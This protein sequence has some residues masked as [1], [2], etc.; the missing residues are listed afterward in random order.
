M[1]DHKILN[2]NEVLCH[3]LMCKIH[4]S[5]EYKTYTIVHAS[6]I[7]ILVKLCCLFGGDCNI[8]DIVQ[9]II[10]IENCMA[11]NKHELNYI[12]A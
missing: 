9:V 2:V 8:T 6:Y 1:K 10:C 7:D 11:N 4:P 5:N 3:P 12:S